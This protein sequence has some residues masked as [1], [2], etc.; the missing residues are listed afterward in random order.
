MRRDLIDTREA[1]YAGRLGY[2]GPCDPICDGEGLTVSGVAAGLKT[3]P[4][5]TLV[6]PDGQVE[7]T[8]RSEIEAVIEALQWALDPIAAV[9]KAAA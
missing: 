7:L 2:D 3:L 8:G 9:R 1:F 5:I 6:G 4:A